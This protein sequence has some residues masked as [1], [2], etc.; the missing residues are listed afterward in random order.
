[1]GSKRKRK[2]T[3][4]SVPAISA[5]RT[6]MIGNIEEERGIGIRKGGRTVERGQ[7]KGEKIDELIT[8]TYEF[9]VRPKINS[10]NKYCL[11]SHPKT[12]QSP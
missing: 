11:I 7:K 3:N 6:G 10:Y 2:C 4:Q 9:N 1:M 8:H 5:L 12:W